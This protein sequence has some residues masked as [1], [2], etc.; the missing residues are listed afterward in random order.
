M[1]LQRINFDFG[2]GPL[3]GKE[4]N[5]VCTQGRFLILQPPPTQLKN[6]N[7]KFLE[8]K[9]IVGKWFEPILPRPGYGNPHRDGHGYC[10]SQP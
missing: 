10:R 4:G 8:L 7:S 6:F 9:F 5:Q 2:R 1:H 3:P